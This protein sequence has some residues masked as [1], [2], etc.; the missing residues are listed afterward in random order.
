M[1]RKTSK[2]F[3]SDNELG[4]STESRKRVEVASWPELADEDRWSIELLE[5]LLESN[6]QTPEEL[7]ARAAEL[8][9][10]CQEEKLPGI[11]DGTLA[12]ADRYEQAARRA[13]ER[14]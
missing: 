1:T 6:E 12:V 4:P 9:E 11:R 5:E 8:R 13:A 14:G 2:G 7:C 10:S 3:A